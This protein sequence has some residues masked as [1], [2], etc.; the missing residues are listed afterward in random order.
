MSSRCAVCFVLDTHARRSTPLV[1]YPT[2]TSTMS[3]LKFNKNDKKKLKAGLSLS[4]NALPP[5]S[6][7]TGVQHG[8]TPTTLR[9]QGKREINKYGPIV[10]GP[11][12]PRAQR[13][14]LPPRDGQFGF[15]LPQL[16]QHHTEWQA[17]IEDANNPDNPFLASSSINPGSSEAPEPEPSAIQFSQLYNITDS[18]PLSTPSTHRQKKLKQHA[19]WVNEV[20]PSLTTPYMELR[21]ST[22]N[23]R[24]SPPSYTP[25]SCSCR[26]TC[27][28][29]SCRGGCAVQSVRVIVLRFMSAYILPDIALISY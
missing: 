11:L 4:R 6:P 2:C 19:R 16:P 3:A 9:H 20:I 23:L 12:G 5:P 27:H 14:D 22:A 15:T 7:A 10:M 26:S 28:H 8:Y 13:K 17:P 29:C 21:S 24:E 18:S 1:E 25:F